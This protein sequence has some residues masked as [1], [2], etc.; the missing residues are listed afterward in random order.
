M[1]CL[2][3]G[4]AIISEKLQLTSAGLLSLS[5]LKNLCVLCA[6]GLKEGHLQALS[7]LRKSNRHLIIL[8][9]Y[10]SEDDESLL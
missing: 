3:Q 9:E 10:D 6:D 4:T 8:D 7:K 2:A 1:R 5:R